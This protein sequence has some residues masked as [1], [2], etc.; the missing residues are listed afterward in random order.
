MK[1]LMA[2][3]EMHEA[4]DGLRNEL[5]SSIAEL[6]AEMRELRREFNM[7]MRWVIGILATN[8]LAVLALIIKSGNFL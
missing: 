3:V 7:Q 4:I 5:H 2:C 8:T 1:R 6:R